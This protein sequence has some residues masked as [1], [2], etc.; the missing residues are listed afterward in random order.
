MDGMQILYCVGIVLVFPIIYYII[1]VFLSS[2]SCGVICLCFVAVWGFSGAS[3]L[4]FPD[5]NSSEKLRQ[6]DT[7]NCTLSNTILQ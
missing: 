4:F 1:L 7:A 5:S 2:P 6:M 3:S